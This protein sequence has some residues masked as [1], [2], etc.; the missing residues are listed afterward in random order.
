MS[1]EGVK[2]AALLGVEDAYGSSRE[3]LRQTTG[4]DLSPNTV[5]AACH[6]IEEQ[7]EA[8]EATAFAQSQ[9]V[10]AQLAQ[11]RQGVPPPR[12][13]GYGYLIRFEN[14]GHEMKAGAFWTT[15]A[16]GRAQAI[17]YYPDTATAGPFGDRGWARA[18]A[19]LANPAPELIFIADGAPWSGRLVE[20]HFPQ[21]IQLVDWFHASSSLVKFA[22]AAYGESSPQAKVWLE[23]VKTALVE[24]KFGPVIRACPALAPLAPI[25]VAVARS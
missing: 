23:P 15:N 3:T 24:G 17:E 4:L 5:R 14:G 6:Q 22:N 1:A 8:R 20:A 10:R 16:E 9:H 13:Y 25:P 19:R 21:A 7:V 11:R 2:V 12:G 18:V